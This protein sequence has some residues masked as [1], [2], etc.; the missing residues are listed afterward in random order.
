MNT[1]E[2]NNQTLVDRLFA[3]GAHFGFS[4]SRRHPSLKKYIFAHKEGTDIFD[5]DQ[6]TKRLEEA[7]AALR[8]VGEKGK[9]VLFVGTKEESARLVHE[10]ATKADMP[11]VVNRWIGGLLTN[12]NEIK[13]RTNRLAA[14]LAERESG[15]AERK[16]TKKERVLINREIDKLTHNFGGITKLEGKPDLMVVVDPRHDSNA[17]KEAV[18]LNIPVVAIM[19]SDCDAN[20][21]TYPIPVNDSL[22]ASVNLVLS[23]LTEAFLEGRKAFT[24]VPTVAPTRSPR[25]AGAVTG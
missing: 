1:Q 18:A 13:K 10:A 6:T 14:L 7:K 5:L 9:K 15:E 22:T 2:S 16:Y 21:I 17:I 19:S 25:S 12:A 8:E 11:F 24:P 4:K 3:A 20:P 23:E